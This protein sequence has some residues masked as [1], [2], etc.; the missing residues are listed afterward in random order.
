M[1]KP[2]IAKKMARQAGVSQ[3]EAADR[4]DVL[5]QEMISNLRKGKKAPLPGVGTFTQGA[6]G[7]IHFE[8]LSGNRKRHA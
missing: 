1:R 8:P 2:G 7:E 4:L 3:A 6:D 5:V